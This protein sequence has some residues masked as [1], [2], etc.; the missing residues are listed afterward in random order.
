MA[1]QDSAMR[2]VPYTLQAAASA[3]GRGLVIAIPKNFREHRITIKG[4]AGVASGAVQPETADDPAYAG[5]WQAIG[6]PVTVVANAELGVSFEGVF[7]FISVRISTVLVGG[8][9]TVT[10]MG[11]PL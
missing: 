10:Y 6:S 7:D 2:G 11:N 9:V 5:T 3:L 1:T 8:T 4:S